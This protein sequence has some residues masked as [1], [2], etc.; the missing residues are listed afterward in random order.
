MTAVPY[1]Q[2]RSGRNPV[3]YQLVNFCEHL[4]VKSTL[5]D[6]RSWGPSFIEVECDPS[7]IIFKTAASEMREKYPQFTGLSVCDT[8][9]F[10][11][12]IHI[13]K[14]NWETIPPASGFIRRDDYRRYVLL[15]EIGHALG[16]GHSTCEHPGTPAPIMMQQTKGTG[17]CLPNPWVKPG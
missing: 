13:L 3:R 15:H 16:H 12:Q 11:T 14:E 4:F 5:N 9:S 1:A 6:L 8:R 17:Q 2:N 10:P 7:I